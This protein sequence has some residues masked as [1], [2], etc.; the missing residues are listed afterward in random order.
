MFITFPQ[1][2]VCLFGT[3]TEEKVR[4]RKKK[5]DYIGYFVEVMNVYIYEYISVLGEE[6]ER[7]RVSQHLDTH[8]CINQN[9]SGKNS[10][11]V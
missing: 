5:K 6:R 8:M 3:R 4:R 2:S 9:I 1:V 11:I 10:L 7:E